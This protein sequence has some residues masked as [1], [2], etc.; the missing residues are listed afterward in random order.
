M[1][2]VRKLEIINAKVKAGNGVKVKVKATTRSGRGR[3]D[4]GADGLPEIGV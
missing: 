4:N 2:E 3:D 1:L